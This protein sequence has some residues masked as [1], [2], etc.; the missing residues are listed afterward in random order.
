MPGDDNEFTPD[1]AP[2]GNYDDIVARH[3]TRTGL[4]PALIHAVIG[5]ESSGRSNA[6]SPKGAG[7]LMQLMPATAA[8]FGVTNVNDPEQNIRGGTDYLKFLHTRYNG[9]IDKTLAGYNAGEGNVDKYGGIPPFRETR[10]YVPAVK[11]R[12]QKLTGKQPAL[13]DT[14]F[15]PDAA[16]TA[17]TPDEPAVQKPTRQPRPLTG[18]DGTGAIGEGTSGYVSP[19][20]TQLA[21]DIDWH[22]GTGTLNAYHQ[23]DTVHQQQ[24]AKRATQLRLADAAKGGP[25]PNEF[26]QNAASPAW[27]LQNRQALGLDKSLP[28]RNEVV[29]QLTRT[30]LAAQQTPEVQAKALHDRSQEIASMPWYQR[31]ALYGLTGAGEAGAGLLRATGIADLSAPFA[32]ARQL[33]QEAAKTNQ[34]GLAEKAEEGALTYAPL[35]L[36]GAPE[37]ALA[38][39][40]TGAAEFG[41][42]SGLQEYGRGSTAGQ[43]LKVGAEQ[44]PLGALLGVPKSV[45]P[46]SSPLVKI[47]LSVAGKGLG[48][49]GLARAEGATNQ[50]ALEQAA[51]IA[52]FQAPELAGA[53][54][55]AARE[56]IGKFREPTFNERTAQQNTVQS[57]AESALFN[58]GVS[59]LGIEKG[60]RSQP[61]ALS[62]DRAAAAPSNFSAPPQNSRTQAMHELVDSGMSTISTAAL[63]AKQ[64]EIETRTD[65]AST[66]AE[67]Y[68][69]AVAAKQAAGEVQAEPALGELTVKPANE[70][71]SAQS[72]PM[73]GRS[74]TAPSGEVGQVEFINDNGVGVRFP[75]RV[76]G[77]QIDLFKMGELKPSEAGYV[78]ERPKPLIAT[79]G[80]SGAVEDAEFKPE[81]PANSYVRDIEVQRAKADAA[82]AKPDYGA[83]RTELMNNYGRYK[84]DYNA[85]D[86]HPVR[87]NGLAT[88]SNASTRDYFNKLR[89]FVAVHN[90]DKL[91]LV[92]QARN[93]EQAGDN[94]K[95]TVLAERALSGTH[96]LAGKVSHANLAL[97]IAEE[98]G[99]PGSLDTALATA[100]DM[101]ERTVEV[102]R[103]KWRG[104][105]GVVKGEPANPQ[106]GRSGA[107]ADLPAAK[108]TDSGYDLRKKPTAGVANF[109]EVSKIAQPLYNAIKS[110]AAFKIATGELD[111]A[112]FTNYVRSQMNERA[113]TEGWHKTNERA[114]YKLVTDMAKRESYDPETRSFR[115]VMPTTSKFVDDSPLNFQ[116]DSTDRTTAR[117]LRREYSGAKNG[118]IVLGNNI[119]HQLKTEVKDKVGREGIYFNTALGGDKTKL[120]SYLN[121]PDPLLDPYRPAI[122]RAL[123]L[124]PWE[125]KWA[126]TLRQGYDELGDYSRSLGTINNVKEDYHN[127]IY[128]KEKAGKNFVQSEAFRQGLGQY[129]GHAKPQI[130]DN[131]L[132]AVL[133][134]YPD[135]S[136][137]TPKKLAVT[138]ANDA[139]SI[140][141]QEMARV[142][143]NAKFRE[144]M[145][146][147]GL[148]KE[149]LAGSKIKDGY[150]AM[151]GMERRFPIQTDEKL[152]YKRGTGWGYT[153]PEERG[154]KI[155]NQQFIVPEGIAKGLNAITD[156]GFAKDSVVGRINE[157][158]GR[159]K[160]LDLAFSAFHHL[161]MLHTLIAQTKGGLDILTHL[162]QMKKWAASGELDAA[163]RDFVRH[164]GMT[165]RVEGNADVMR[166]LIHGDDV[167]SRGT[168]LPVIK[169]VLQT[170]EKFSDILFDNI[171]RKMKVIDYANKAAAWVGSHLEATDRQIVEAKRS[172]ASEINAAYGGLNWTALGVSK[173]SLGWMRLLMLAP[174]WTVSNV[175]LPLK[176]GSVLKGDPGGKAALS[177]IVTATI[178]SSL[179]TLGLNHVLHGKDNKETLALLKAGKYD[180]AGASFV[181]Q[182]ELGH[183]LEVEVAPGVYIPMFRGGISDITKVIGLYR[184]L[185]PVEG[186]LQFASNKASP[187]LRTAIG[188]MSNTVQGKPILVPYNPTNSWL[189]NTV[190]QLKQTG[191][192]VR[193]ALPLPL[194]ITQAASYLTRKDK[195]TL[196]GTATALSGAGKVTADTG[197]RTEAEKYMYR[198]NKLQ[199]HP[200]YEEGTDAESKYQIKSD[201]QDRMRAGEKIN[202]PLSA[203]VKSG[204]LGKDDIVDIIRGGSITQFTERFKA[205]KLDNAIDVYKLADPDERKAID[206]QGLLWK[207]VGTTLPKLS[208]NEQKKVQE[209]LRTELP[210]PTKAAGVSLAQE[211]GVPMPIPQRGANEDDTGYRARLLQLGKQRSTKLDAVANAPDFERLNPAAQR[212]AMHNALYA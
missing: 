70:R 118:Q 117:D 91:D 127:R 135:G 208:P 105:E 22:F 30:N 148:G 71:I 69:N 14:T 141:N 28:V 21:H 57:A 61:T 201:L 24:I 62:V 101:R 198:L 29:S 124:K 191:K 89:N 66:A 188:V 88:A 180:E 75:K 147:S 210:K 92:D 19:E 41:G 190:A 175:L 106:Y 173:S 196:L 49:Y 123:N 48:T 131:V 166:D 211:L 36:G 150:K 122:E 184:E 90:P 142:N 204:Q 140:L 59:P 154:A 2:A 12:Y 52:G 6:R 82:E 136:Q 16:D 133:G 80:T 120:T 26:G 39:M 79:Y 186:S 108:K 72:S 93:Y 151:P 165:T 33:Q 97:Q 128:V 171:Q 78:G 134:H 95:A 189:Q 103:Q 206:S 20:S 112:K 168:R 170:A 205:L 68:R 8:R 47:G 139:Y 202:A 46:F 3:A 185:G 162:P 43:A 54:I 207:K 53:G 132:D 176:M 167:L 182:R 58:A 177:H 42:Y 164:T 104:Q 74:V 178:A 23:L 172:I 149:V 65:V 193:P 192:M 45:I 17:F 119:A 76:E 200:I 156:A 98:G 38:K 157:V 99:K 137:G 9:D 25:S 51:M 145:V 121:N 125:Q 77:A 212:K 73:I 159:I 10:N 35:M 158:Q 143:T 109:D 203:A 67:D 60:T 194:G 130:Y 40:A 199:G 115:T 81:L 13:T 18:W 197:P 85:L 5:Q 102:D 160:T 56:G 1:A 129:T 63:N 87:K 32:E 7:G 114:A 169:Q 152:T 34:P 116:I 4:D 64:A 155:L 183:E 44:A 113:G 55:R 146:A 161:A 84:S 15:T 94:V 37:G 187:F 100:A 96:D 27:Q 153:Q 126:N 111:P 179:A 181:G 86:N 83:V 209:R 195:P 138:E 31:G 174:D 107:V 11:A 50:Q 163:E 144:A 110:D